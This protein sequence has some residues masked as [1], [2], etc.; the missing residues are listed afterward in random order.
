M[1]AYSKISC[2]FDLSIN[3]NRAIM[4]TT[5]ISIEQLAE[6]LGGKI[7]VKGDLKRIYLY[8][9]YNTK[10]MSTK[11]YVYE[12]NGDF[13]VSCVI[14]CN[15]QPQAWIKSQEKEVID[16]VSEQIEQVIFNLENPDID[17]YEEKERIS[18]EKQLAREIKEAEFNSKLPR[19]LA[20]KYL[21]Q[22]KRPDDYLFLTITS[23]LNRCGYHAGLFNGMAL[24][25]PA[26]FSKSEVITDLEIKLKPL[27]YTGGWDFD[28]NNLEVVLL[29]VDKVNSSQKYNYYSVSL[30]EE[31]LLEVL[32][33]TFIIKWEQCKLRTEQYNFLIDIKVNEL[34]QGEDVNFWE[35]KGEIYTDANRALL[36]SIKEKVE[37]VM[38]F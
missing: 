35:L 11:T 32:P 34:L 22:S 31:Q 26:G 5:T 13:R 3:K 33:K 19:L 25:S 23:Y 12:Y 24:S 14:E 30:T 28:E 17:F 20:A 15:S 37:S 2:K 10:K 1:F 8:R 7:W 18:N 9:G 36:D 6:L 16:S 4:T 21:K 27:L 38:P 29:S